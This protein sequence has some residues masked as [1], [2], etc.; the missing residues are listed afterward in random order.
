V[1]PSSEAPARLPG[2]SVTRRRRG[3]APKTLTGWTAIAVLTAALLACAGSDDDAMVTPDPAVLSSTD[4]GDGPGTAITAAPTPS[5]VET[6]PAIPTAGRPAVSEP[7]TTE[8]TAPSTTSTSSTIAERP[9][10]TSAVTGAP[11]ATVPTA[12][13]LRDGATSYV[14]PSPDLG[15]SWANTHAGYTATDIFVPGG[16]G[17]DV[18]SPVDGVVLEVRRVDEWDPAVDNPATRGGRSIAILGNDGVRY[19]LAHFADIQPAL[20]P[21]VRV[22][23]GERL[24]SVGTT[25]RSSA[26]HIHVGISPPCPEREWS[27]RRGAIWPYPYLDAWR[28]GE[29]LSP[30]AEIRSWT[31]EHPDA[32]AVAALD[33]YAG[34]A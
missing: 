19:Y 14:V 18:V 30:V 12:P 6:T 23:A 5:P 22:A 3:R 21:D 2:R 34:D 33:P 11:T 20:A 13:E 27:I 28:R 10:E 15:A 7:P 16:C 25:G 26:C 31:A 17:G 4:P 9:Q 8:A 1:R 29:Q 24:G 32:C